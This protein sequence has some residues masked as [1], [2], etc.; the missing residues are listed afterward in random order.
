[1]MVEL[2]PNRENYDDVYPE[3]SD[4]EDTDEENDDNDRS[5]AES[6]AVKILAKE[7]RQNEDAVKKASEGKACASSRLAM[8]ENYARS[9]ENDRPQDLEACISIYTDQRRKAYED[10][11]ACDTRIGELEQ[12]RKK[13]SKRLTKAMRDTEK[14][15]AKVAKDK[16]KRMEKKCRAKQ[17]K[18]EAKNRLRR[19]RSEFWPRNVY[20][21]VLSL[22][23]N[24]EITPSSSRRASVES[25]AK[26]IR[27]DS[28]D[29]CQISLSLSYITHFAWWSPRYDLSLNTPNNSGHIIYSAEFCNGTSEV[30]KDA[31]VILS[32][33][34][35]SF[36]GL[37]ELIPSM[38]AWHIR[39]SRET[40]AEVGDIT[41]GAL[42]STY[43][44]DYKKRGQAAVSEKVGEPRNALFGIDNSNVTETSF[45]KYNHMPTPPMRPQASQMQQAQMQ[46]AYQQQAYQQRA[47]QRA[48]QQA[49]MQQVYQHQAQAS[50]LF[51]R[52]NAQQST[53]GAGLFGNSAGNANAPSGQSL[54]GMASRQVAGNEDASEAEAEYDGT[55]ETIISELPTLATQESEWSETG[56][57]AT[58]DIPGL[59][60][61]TPS[62]TMRRHKIASITLRDVHLSYILVPKLRAA[63]FLK[64][65]IRNTSSITLLKGPVGLTLDGSFLGNASFPR[66]SAGE[67]F[68]LSLGVDP[69]VNV[70]Y[71]KPVVKRSQTGVFQK[72]GSGVY[73]RTITITNTK[74]NRS[75]EGLVLDQIPVSEDERL[76]I[77]ILQPSGLRSE[78]DTAKSGV[79]IAA[80][81]K[82]TEKWGTARATLKK[83]GEIR[84]NI[85]LEASRGVKLVLEYEARFPST[86]MVVGC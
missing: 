19:E 79:G 46:Q 36:H 21:V 67:P 14:E 37:A 85:N 3:A 5:D 28:M 70:T 76:K 17:E 51:G 66:C 48:Q 31:K 4:N 41:S 25:L 43:E 74:S 52:Q 45:A 22:D 72:E 2:I 53:R 24:S 44:M 23:T 68:S 39:L 71:S 50:S 81:G 38:Q 49:Q 62:H 54:F 59:R 34:Q 83:A 32:T 26:M 65:R 61:I 20:S 55:G 47:Q 57:T 77:D 84:W 29:C 64:A 1:M 12:Q 40:F 30:W 86:E 33:S 6:E 16:M 69:S 60:T 11:F 13:I 27:E 63:A 15:K 7:K 73:T 9:I 82:V 78:G 10:H 80:V 8:L 42:L 56:M 75:V 58:Y 35:T 18:V